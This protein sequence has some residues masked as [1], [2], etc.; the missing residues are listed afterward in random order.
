[1]SS[2]INDTLLAI[3][4]AFE[5]GV[6]IF[7]GGTAVS[8]SNPLPVAQTDGLSVSGTATSAAV[9]FTTS[10]LNYESITVQ[11]TSAGT[12]CTVAYEQSEDQ[13]IWYSVSGIS[14]T[15]YG[16]A[17]PSSGTTSVAMYIFPRKGTYFRARVATYGLAGSTVT[18]IGTLSKTPV[19]LTVEARLGGY[20]N[21]GAAITNQPVPICL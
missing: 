5:A 4:S 1:M 19:N 12:S 21:E 3:K 14:V 10:M 15:N 9:L 2:V 18:A 17:A 6:N 20:A 8:S 13:T 7:N 16:S 11:V